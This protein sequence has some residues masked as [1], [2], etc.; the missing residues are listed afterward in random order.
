MEDECW[1]VFIREEI[2]KKDDSLDIGL[3]VD[4]L[5]FVYENLLD[6]IELVEEVIV[7]F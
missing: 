5:L 2:V 6:L 4:E 1:N 7:K 3:I